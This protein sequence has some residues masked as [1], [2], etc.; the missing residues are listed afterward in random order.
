MPAGLL[1]NQPSSAFEGDQIMDRNTWH[2]RRR[3]VTVAVTSALATLIAVG[4]LSAVAGLFQSRGLPL[5]ELVAAERACAVHA[6]VSDR[7]T[8]MR[9]WIAAA[10]GNHVVRQ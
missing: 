2:E 8:C 6:Y 4:I 3:A 1:S 10:H 9:N 7:E 5:E